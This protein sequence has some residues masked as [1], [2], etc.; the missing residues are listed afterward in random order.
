M[1]EEGETI[2]NDIAM[3][4]SSYSEKKYEEHFKAP[5]MK[6][7]WKNVTYK[8]Q[9]KYTK[10]ERKELGITETHYDKVILKEQDGYVNHGETLFIMGSS[11]A[12][13]T[14]LLNVLA[15]RITQNR[16]SKLGGEILVND[17]YPVSQKDFGRY[18]AYVMQD[19]ILF[20]TLR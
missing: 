4:K 20:Q 14:T 15:D 8:V 3:K 16:R 6:L 11:G 9:V 1:V 19:D 7:S 2:H 12:G 18:G 10:K 5:P 17:S 13:K